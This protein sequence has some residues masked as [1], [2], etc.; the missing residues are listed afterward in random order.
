MLCLFSCLALFVMF[1]CADM[2]SSVLGQSI[3]IDEQFMKLKDVRESLSVRLSLA[4]T[5]PGLLPC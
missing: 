1:P 3:G 5:S 2:Y 4:R